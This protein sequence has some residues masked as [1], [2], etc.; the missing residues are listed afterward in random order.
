M[1][2]DTTGTSSECVPEGLRASRYKIRSPSGMSVISISIFALGQRRPSAATARPSHQSPHRIAVRPTATG[3]RYRLH[4]MPPLTTA[5]TVGSGG[6]SVLRHH[7]QAQGHSAVRQAGYTRT[8]LDGCL[9]R[10]PAICATAR[11]GE[12]EK[13]PAAARSGHGRTQH[14]PTGEQS[15]PEGVS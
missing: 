14:R 11:R 1:S 13:W 5:P 9:L 2:L 4:P 15:V 8:G 10:E 12:N 6:P 3:P 7:R